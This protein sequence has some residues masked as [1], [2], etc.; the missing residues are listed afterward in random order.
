MLHIPCLAIVASFGLAT[1]LPIE[2]AE[3]VEYLGV[4]AKAAVIGSADAPITIWIKRRVFNLLR[5][6]AEVARA[7]D[8]NGMRV[9]VL[10]GDASSAGLPAGVFVDLIVTNADVA[11]QLS[12]FVDDACF[13]GGFEGDCP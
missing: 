12:Q 3:G 10:T 11:G 4:E 5:D 6:E 1:A 8:G 9:R 13:L 7:C 2:G